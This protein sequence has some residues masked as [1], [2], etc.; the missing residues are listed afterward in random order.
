MKTTAL[1]Q[2]V[3]HGLCAASLWTL[4]CSMTWAQTF[5]NKPIRIIVG[6][7]AGGGGDTAARILAQPLSEQLGQSIVIENRPGAGGNIGADSVAKASPDGYTLLWAYT[8]HVINP[9]LYTKLPF[10]TLRD[11]APVA[12]VAT[13]QTMLVVRPSLPVTSVQELVVYAKK[14][15]GK[16]TMG[17]LV[18]SSQHLAGELFKSV[19]NINI[20]F[21]PYKGASQALNAMLAGEIDVMFNTVSIMQPH[22]KS[23][24]VRALA[25]TGKTRS[26]VVPNL[27]SIN[28]AGFPTYSSVGWYGLVAPART[29]LAIVEKLHDA[30]EKSLARPD[31]KAKMLALGNEPV[32]MTPAAFSSFVEEEIPRWSR[33]IKDANV[34]NE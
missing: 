20:L 27:P 31:I 6:S 12:M 2:F 3:I 8:G 33:V 25:V 16:L 26:S 24:K 23:G 30:V 21:V 11:F 1:R 14:E 19:A 5:P 28:E 17:T 34:P 13:N 10:D 15:P 18:G 22:V 29:P 9:G 7:A 4:L 32:S